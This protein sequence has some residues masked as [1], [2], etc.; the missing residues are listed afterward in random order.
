MYEDEEHTERG[1]R[2]P[3]QDLLEHRLDVRERILVRVIRE[4]RISD[5][6]IDLSLRLVLDFR[7]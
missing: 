5:H 4:A 2:V 3:A 7:V 6:A 1:D